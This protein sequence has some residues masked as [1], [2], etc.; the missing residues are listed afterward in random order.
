M[1]SMNL[2]SQGQT[3]RVHRESSGVYQ[4][5]SGGRLL[6]FV[7]RAGDVYV[8]LSGTRYD[9]AVETGQAGSLGSAAV[10][11]DAA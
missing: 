2:V 9:R 6:G 7:E 1:S 3:F 11:L 10:L 5:Q 8:A 4:V